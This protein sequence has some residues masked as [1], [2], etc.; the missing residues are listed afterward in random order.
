MKQLSKNNST[1]LFTLLTGVL[2]VVAFISYNK[3]LQFNQS[4]DLV[5]RTNEVKNK[6][7]EIISNLKDAEIGQ[8][9]YL[10]SNDSAFL[11][12]Y[13]D[14]EERS[15]FV[16]TS[17]DSLIS[18]N[19]NQ[20]ENL[21]KLKILINE[22]YELLDFNLKYLK[23]NHHNL[24]ADK[25]ILKGKRKMDEVRKQ[26]SIILQS[27]DKLLVEHTHVKNRTATIT[28]IFLLGLSLFSIVVITLF[29][30]RLQ[31]ET[32]ERISTTE[33]NLRLQ[34][35]NKLI[36]A[37]EKEQKKLASQLKLAT[38]SANIGIWS[39]NVV[40]SELEWSNLHKK[41]WGYDEHC[42]NLTYEDW[43]KVIVPEDK[44]LAF[45]KIE[46][47]KV[48][49]SIYE[50]DYRINRANDGAI[51]WIKSTGQFYF[52]DLGVAQTLT[53][54][55]IDIT[56]HKSFTKDLESKVKKRTAE[57]TER[58][59]FI[60]TLIDSSIDSIIVFDKELRY[61]NMNKIATQTFAKHFSD[62]VIG[63]KID[64]ITP[65]V[66][67]T[68]AYANVLLALKG[69]NVSRKEFKSF[70]EEKYYDV[71]YIPI[72]NDIEIYGVMVITR[73]VTENVVAALALK[74]ANAELEERKN[75]VETILEISKEY[76]AVYANDFTLLSINKAVETLLGKS[77]EDVIGKK[78]LEIL[79]HAK[80]TKS[81]TDLQS[82]FDGNNV[83][84]EPY[85]SIVT[86]RYIENYITP[87][88]DNQGNVYAALAIANDVTNIVVKQKEIE[89]ANKR[90]QM[91]N[92]TFELA[93]NIAKLGSYKWNITTG[94]L[95]YSDNLFRLFDCEP[96]EF[97]P[98][99]EKFLSFV[100]PEDLA[101][102]IKNGEQTIQT[103]V[104]VETP[105]RII[106]KTGK[107]K[108]LRSSGNFSGEGANSLLMGTVQDISNDVEASKELKAKNLELENANAELASFSYVASH[109]L[110]EPLRKIQVFSK[111]IIDKDGE[112]LSETTKDYFNRINAAAQRMR[113]LIESL[114][115]FSRTIHGVIAYER[116]DLNEILLEVKNDLNELIIQKNA[117]IES[118]TLP[119]L[120]AVPVL[121]H[122]LFL[123]LIG[124]SLKYSKDEIAPQIRIT[125]EK[126]TT[127][128]KAGQVNQQETFW[129]IVISDN[130]IGFEQQYE[131]K[132][133]EVFQRLHGK[134][135]FEGTGI[136]LAICKKIVQLHKGTIAATAELNVGATFTFFL[137]VNNKS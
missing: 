74:K 4:V 27:E 103:G 106:S 42:E 124:N 48:N 125:A 49:H 85:K 10:L 26:V 130:G 23:N 25:Y 57:L 108:Y 112:S 133:F 22:R 77:R 88:R 71:D 52:D 99:F 69:N 54:I 60:E 59:I 16:F 61:L 11:Q 58:N 115:S 131:H 104:L 72:K 36:E 117:V 12:S 29:F 119:V 68:G 44:E 86:G 79:P 92:Q 45:K 97:V 132:I 18:N 113:K 93:E 91:Q 120:N 70:F 9:G 7:V 3:I 118:Q 31:K 1:L 28:P 53:G 89:T 65:Q 21:K 37:S 82:A 33:S 98:S 64:E 105:Y 19:P 123:N 80:G 128:E 13:I 17:L 62:S 102:V 55:S 46:E 83:Y 94:E 96:Q 137:S 34:D 38:D 126:V 51:V 6:I 107:I 30:L 78:L 121:M 127:N 14:A 114:L 76:I 5:M 20:K 109:D 50:V 40:S 63:K 2:V 8:R 81:E 87:L 122:Q 73:D 32:N 47:A 67:Q 75:L 100:H 116:T 24:V 56:E 39:L 41:M 90:L 134:T 95:E 84:N 136:G 35:A 110:Q 66:H 43:H 129:K 111:R 101:Q 15:N 135:T